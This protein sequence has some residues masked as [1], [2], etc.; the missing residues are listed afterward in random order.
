M[1]RTEGNALIAEIPAVLKLPD[2]GAFA[3]E[4]LAADIMSVQAVQ[5]DSDTIRI[6][7]L[8][9]GT[10]P[11]TPVSLKTGGFT[12]ALKPMTDEIDEVEEEEITV[13][14][15]RKVDGVSGAE[16]QQCHR[17]RYP[18]FGNTFFDPSHSPGSD[19]RS[20]GNSN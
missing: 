10:V 13:T 1:F 11:Q 12:Y 5:Q 14:A 2:D 3:A 15:E 19:S 6:T 18:N 4:N 17:Y 9:M 7:V 16:C 8:G 20:T